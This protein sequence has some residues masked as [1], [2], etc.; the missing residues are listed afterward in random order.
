MTG[1]DRCLGVDVKGRREQH[2]LRDRVG[3]LLHARHPFHATVPPRWNYLPC[4]PL[5]GDDVDLRP[6]I[7]L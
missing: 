5:T 3:P 4:G 7:G 1:G 6:N 2:L